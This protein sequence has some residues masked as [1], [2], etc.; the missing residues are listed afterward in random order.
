MVIRNNVFHQ[1]RRAITIETHPLRGASQNLHVYQNTQYVDQDPESKSYFCNVSQGS[2]GVVIRNNLAVLY[3]RSDSSTFVSGEASVIGNYVYAPSQPNL[4]K[5]PDGSRSCANPN[6]VN[7]KDPESPSFM[8]PPAGS[9]AIDA[10][11]EVPM[12]YDFHGT[13]RPQGGSQDIGAVERPR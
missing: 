1:V 2:S 6:L 7:V 3:S 9:L 12:P 4:C 8:L 13:L 10:A 5:L 11:A